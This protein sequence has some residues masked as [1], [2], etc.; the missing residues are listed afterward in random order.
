MEEN[1]QAGPPVDAEPTFMECV[2]DN[3][4]WEDILGRGK[5]QTFAPFG[6]IAVGAVKR[7]HLCSL[8]YG[9]LKTFDPYDGCTRLTDDCS[10]LLDIRTQFQLSG[11]GN[12][13][14]IQV[15]CTRPGGAQHMAILQLSTMPH[16]RGTPLIHWG[17]CLSC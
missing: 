14:C 17:F 4:I 1:T 8:L 7:C 10:C 12:C 2:C 13:I 15:I 9:G 5:A 16:N 11:E 3:F 6:A